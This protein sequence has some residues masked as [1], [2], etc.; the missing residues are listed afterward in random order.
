MLNSTLQKIM[1]VD[2]EED[3]RVIVQYTL[4]KIGKFEVKSCDSGQQFLSEVKEF[5]PDLILMDMMMPNMDGIMTINSYKEMLDVIHVPVIFMTAKVQTGDIVY[6]K[7]FGAA[8]VIP[9]PFNAK[10]LS[11]QLIDMY[12]AIREEK[13]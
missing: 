8:N 5:S 12:N 3:I 4:E 13:V 6:Y 1:I 10:M 2:D 9:K 7:T 11:S